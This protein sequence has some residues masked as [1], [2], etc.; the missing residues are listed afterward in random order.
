MPNFYN[1]VPTMATADW[2]TPGWV[3]TYIGGNFAAGWVGTTAGDMDYY[4]SSVEKAR[5]AKPASIGLLQNNAGGVPSWLTGGSAFQVLR[6]N[7][8]NT[9]LEWASILASMVAGDI[10]YASDANVFG[11]LPKPASLGLLMNDA[12]G[13]PSYFTGGAALQVL[14]KNAANT[15][16][17]WADSLPTGGSPLQFLRK[18][19]A[20]TGFEWAPLVAKRQGGSPTVWINPGTTNYDITDAFIQIGY[21]QITVASTSGST[22]IT[23]PTPFLSQRPAIFLTAEMT[24]LSPNWSL[25]HSNDTLNGFRLDLKFVSSA[26]GTYTCGW[27]AIGK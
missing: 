11:R 4:A 13:V 9:A 21:C 10:P 15:A 26:P 6:K 22:T 5:L 3:N 27:M 7:A 19:A 18:N 12:A 2:I 20:G 24:I 8:A 23:Y 14:R 16:F 25:G 17:E 1:V